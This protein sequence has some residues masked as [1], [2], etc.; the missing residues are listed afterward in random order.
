MYCKTIEFW[1]YKIS[2]CCMP[3]T[4]MRILEELAEQ[5]IKAYRERGLNGIFLK[6]ALE[7]PLSVEHLLNEQ[8]KYKSSNV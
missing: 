6:W 5:K 1:G 7:G 2:I 8:S 4:P 3:D